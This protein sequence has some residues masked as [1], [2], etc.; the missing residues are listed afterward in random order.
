MAAH[1]LDP[2]A[3]VEQFGFRQKLRHKSSFA[4]LFVGGL[5]CMAVIPPVGM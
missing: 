5:V 2:S 3:G 1:T 4:H